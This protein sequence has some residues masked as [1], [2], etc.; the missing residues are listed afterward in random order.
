MIPVPWDDLPRGSS[1]AVIAVAL[2][3]W[4]VVSMLNT[5]RRRGFVT[6]FS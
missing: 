1:G 4:F 5:F 6:R 2:A 3:F